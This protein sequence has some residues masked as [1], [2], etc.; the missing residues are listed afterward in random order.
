MKYRSIGGCLRN[1][2]C[3]YCIMFTRDSRKHE[4]VGSSSSQVA[5]ENSWSGME[6]QSKQRKGE[7]TDRNGKTRV[8]NNKLRTE[9]AGTWRMYTEWMKTDSQNKLWNGHQ[10]MEIG[11]ESDQERTGSQRYV[12]PW[13][14]WIWI[15][16]Q[17][18]IWQ[19]TDG[20]GVAVLPNVLQAGLRSKV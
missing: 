14:N 11:N 9:M 13:R 2:N 8:D 19:K 17:P 5:K 12:R 1:I 3:Y 4:E 20:R 6:G 7:A 18:K 15:G 10:Y 16:I